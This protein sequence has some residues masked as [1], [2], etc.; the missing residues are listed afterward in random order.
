MHKPIKNTL[1]MVSSIASFFHNS[2]IRMNELKQI[3]ATKTLQLL[4][5]PKLFEIR[6]TEYTFTGVNNILFSWQALVAYF[7]TN[8][9]KSC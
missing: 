1:N 8:K 4:S 3:A 6:W 7:T 5:L 9:E 2:S